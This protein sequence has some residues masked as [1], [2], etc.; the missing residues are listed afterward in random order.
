MLTSAKENMFPPIHF[1]ISV[2]TLIM[3][4]KLLSLCE[5]KKAQTPMGGIYARAQKWHR[6][7]IT[8]WW[9]LISALQNSMR[10]YSELGTLWKYKAFV[11]LVKLSFLHLV[12]FFENCFIVLMQVLIFSNKVTPSQETFLLLSSL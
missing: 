1:L 11:E 7:V 9:C 2:N 8:V 5:F 3:V 6:S 4:H 10:A 12:V